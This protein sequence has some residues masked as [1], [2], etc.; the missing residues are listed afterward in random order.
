ML[1]ECFHLP[2]CWKSFLVKKCFSLCQNWSILLQKRV[3]GLTFKLLPLFLAILAI[4]QSPK[5]GPYTI[6]TSNN[7]HF[8]FSESTLT[9]NSSWY[10]SLNLKKIIL[11]EIFFFIIF[12]KFFFIIFLKFF[13][14]IREYISREYF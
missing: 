9:K 4:L 2:V 6:Y 12:L 1:K 7:R 3:F 5:K 10:F 13:L 14:E 8:F 11:F